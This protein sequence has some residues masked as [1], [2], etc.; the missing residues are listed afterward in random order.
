[1]TLVTEPLF[2]HNDP[3]P[4]SVILAENIREAEAELFRRAQELLAACA[5]TPPTVTDDETAGKFADLVKM[6]AACI[7]A[8]DAKRVG[9]KEPYLSCGRAV[10]GAFKTG[11]LDPLL[12]AKGSVESTLGVYLRQKADRE[13]R[14]R[15]EAERLAREAERQAQE[16]ARKAA[17]AMQNEKDLAAALDAQAR[18]DEAAIASVAA[19]KA[20]AAKPAD[21]ARTRGD[22]GSL[23]TLRTHW[24]FDQVTLDRATLDL[25]AL[26]EHLPRDAIDR[27][28][29]S[30][31]KAG[32]RELRGARIYE[33]QDVIVR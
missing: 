6:V 33:A 19:S 14:A 8:A 21:M 20:A 23:G 30:F 28:I 17:E 16:A 11:I 22:V 7:N 26:R 13:R 29:R 1:M 9:W 27:A 4:D 5:R 24:D 2:G 32:G 10:D 25:E 31:I 12:K 18:A 15:E 3:P